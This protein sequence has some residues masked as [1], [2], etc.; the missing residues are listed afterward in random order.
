MSDT[1]KRIGGLGFVGTKSGTYGIGFDVDNSEQSLMF[2]MHNFGNWESDPVDVGG[3]RV[4]PWGSDNNLPGYIRRL[5]EKN[6]LGPANIERKIGLQYGQGP[7][8]YR[9]KFEN[10]EITREWVEDS[11]VQAWLDTW[12][13]KEFVRNALQEFNFMRGIFVKIHSG[14][15]RRLG[16]AWISKL[17][18]MLTTECRLQWPENGRRLNDCTNII[19]GDFENM[20]RS[21]YFR[22]PVFDPQNPT[23]NPVSLY[24]HCFRTF[25]RFFYPLPTFTGAIPWIK[26]A[27]DLPEIIAY[28]TENMIAAAYHVHEPAAYWQEKRDRLQEINPEWDDAQLNNEID[29]MRDEVTQSIANVLAG[30]R[31]SGK[32]FE[33]IDFIDPDGNKCEWKIEPIEMNIDKF[34]EAQSKISRIAE[35][36]TTSSFGLN[37]ALSNIIIDG[38]SDSG[39]QMLY[40]AKLFYA[41]DTQ[42][43]EDIVFESINW[44]ININFPGKKLAMG[45]YRKIVN[46]EDNVTASQ[47]ATNNV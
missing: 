33:S 39:S 44:A 16:K 45:L 26:R 15:A 24:L 23:E 6:N 1:V 27:N 2:S 7:F 18:T 12:N 37:P 47:R 22:Y 13:Y 42:I 36:A 21:N 31:N 30:K 4:V 46:K 8:L 35:S 25:G 11:E 29:T 38:K 40:A 5:L 10:N 19:I 43:A 28:L 9:L 32:F 20:R 17:E 14:R 3:V 41:S 34:I